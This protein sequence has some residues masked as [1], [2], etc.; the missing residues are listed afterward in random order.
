MNAQSHLEGFYGRYG[1][2]PSGP[3]FMEDGIEHTPLRREAGL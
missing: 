3:R 1:F 2:V